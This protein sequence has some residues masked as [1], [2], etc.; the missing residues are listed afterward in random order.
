MVSYNASYLHKIEVAFKEVGIKLRYEKGSFNSGY[1]LLADQKLVV[2]NKFL[3]IEAKINCL[4]EIL[5][6]LKI[7]DQNL[8]ASTRKI[9]SE[10]Y[11]TRLSIF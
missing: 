5:P 11:Q 2:I 4:I 6:S 8:T 10:M 9:L 1:C 3:D 7:D